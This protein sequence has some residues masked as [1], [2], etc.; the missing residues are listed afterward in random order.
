MTYFC[1]VFLSTDLTIRD[2]SSP[3]RRRWKL[4]IGAQASLS[5]LNETHCV[6]IS[7]IRVHLLTTI[8][9]LL[10]YLV[11]FLKL[12]APFSGM[13]EPCYVVTPTVS[14][15][16]VRTAVAASNTWNALIACQRCSSLATTPHKHRTL[17]CAHHLSI[18]EVHFLHRQRC[19]TRVVAAYKSKKSVDTMSSLQHIV[20]TRLELSHPLS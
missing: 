6:L 14:A 5:S 7:V 13:N 3:H 18:T 8:R 17:H 15:I 11:H 12:K 9:E 20:A 16:S 1:G 19:R 10:A 4:F 2:R